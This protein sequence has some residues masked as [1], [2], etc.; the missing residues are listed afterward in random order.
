MDELPIIRIP[1][2]ENVPDDVEDFIEDDGSPFLNSVAD[3]PIE[4]PIVV[5]EVAEATKKPKKPL[6]DKQ[7]A[8]LTKARA[9]AQEKAKIKRDM[10]NAL[11][12]KVLEELK[13]PEPTPKPPPPPHQ[14]DEDFKERMKIPTDEEALET[15][16][17]LEEGE[18]FRFH[19]RMKKYE[20]FQNYLKKDAEERDRPVHIVTATPKHKPITP[21][22]SPKL[23]RQSL[24]KPIPR[25]PY[26]SLFD[27]S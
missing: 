10:K 25:N 15:K 24:I 16:R 5:L 8:H 20:A 22:P 6:S 7:R 4:E 2:P 12:A 17:T 21:P 27:W 9:K 23:P 18:F 14:L 19:A 11:E 13:K 3:A 26:D 1:T